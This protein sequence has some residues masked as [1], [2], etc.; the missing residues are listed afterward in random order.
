MQE[1]GIGFWWR[2][3]ILGPSYHLDAAQTVIALGGPLASYSPLTEEPALF[4]VFADTPPLALNCLALANQ[5]GRLGLD[6]PAARAPLLA[7]D[8]HTILDP[9]SAEPV[10]AWAEKINWLRGLVSLW[11]AFVTRREGL[12]GN[13][14]WLPDGIEFFPGVTQE[15]I[16]QALREGYAG[17]DIYRDLAGESGTVR[18]S[19]E[20]ARR[21]SFH[22]DDISG[23][24]LTYL[25]GELNRE[26]MPLLAPAMRWE[27][28]DGLKL[29][30]HP[31]SLWGAIC[32][33][34]I[35]A[36]QWDKRFQRC[37]ACGRWFELGSGAN[38]TDRTT[39]SDQ[40]RARL[41]RVRQ[42]RAVELFQAGK[43]VKEIATEL[44]SDVKTVKGWIGRAK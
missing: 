44:K 35:L 4:H 9:A 28:S 39:C 1:G 23:P 12:A 31:R 8:G 13:V 30:L 17:E 29:R 25:G 7:M 22:P 19:M 34:F 38:R 20:E 11:D 6:E 3:T 42:A 32:A 18:W 14:R 24:I 36:I 37:S 16:L 33:Q 26:A 10:A 41:Y 43:T 2:R 5:Y 27:P 15:R 40:C 21:L